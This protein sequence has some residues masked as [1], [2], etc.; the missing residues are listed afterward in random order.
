[1]SVTSSQRGS[2]RSLRP[3]G[4][5]PAPPPPPMNGAAGAPGASPGKPGPG[6]PAAVSGRPV[7][8]C[9]HRVS[10]L[11]ADIR[12]VD[13]GFSGREEIRGRPA[14]PCAALNAQGRT[15]LTWDRPSSITPALRPA[16][17]D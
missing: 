12:D 2:T 17:D 3:T 5:P 13:V 1:V 11:S 4:P 15:L 16:A 14:N 6:F 7:S 8:A 10:T 9:R